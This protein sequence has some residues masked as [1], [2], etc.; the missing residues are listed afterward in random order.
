MKKPR[1]KSLSKKVLALFLSIAMVFG[2]IP[3]AVKETKAATTVSNPRI[4][5]GV[6]TW[7]CIYFGNYYQSNSST[8]EKIKWRVLS[9]EGNYAFVVA[10]QALDYK[11]YNEERTDVTWETCSLRK[12]L[13]GTFLNTAFN[14]T[15]QS[16]IKTTTVVNEDNI[17]DIPGGNNTSDK[18]FLLS[19]NEVGNQ[20]YGFNSDYDEKSETRQCKA[21]A[22]AYVAVNCFWWLRSPG[23]WSHAA[24]DVCDDGRGNRLG[25]NVVYDFGVRPALNVNLSSSSWSYGGTVSANMGKGSGSSTP[26]SAPTPTK[27]P[28]ASSDKTVGTSGSVEIGENQSGSADSSSGVSQFFPDSWTMKSTKYPLELSQTTNADGTYSIKGSIGIGR[29]D[30]LDK[31]SE[32]KKYKAACDKANKTMS[33]YDTLLAY[34]DMFGLKSSTVIHSSGWTGST[35][36]ELSIMGYIENTYDAY[37]NLIKADGRV[38][39][40]MAWKGGTTW[41][42]ATPIG[43]MYLKFEAG[44]KIN[45]SLGP[46]WDNKV[47][48]MALNGSLTITPSISLTGGYGFDGVISVS[49]KGQCSLPIDLVSRNQGTWGSKGTFKAEASVNAYAI[50]V[51]DQTWTL[52]T[53]KKTLWDTSTL[54]KSSSKGTMKNDVKTKLMSTD[55]SEE[56]TK[57][58]GKV[59]SL[60]S[61]NAKTLQGGILKSSIP[62]SA[63]IS[64]KNVLVWQDYAPERSV[65]NSSILKY[66]VEKNGVWSTPKPVYDDGFGDSFVDLKV[67]KDE[68]YIVWQKQKKKITT[69]DVDEVMGEMGASSE[70]YFAKFNKTKDTFENVKQLTNNSECDMLPKFTENTDEISITYI[71]NDRGDINQSSG[72]NTIKCMNVTEETTKDLVTTEQAIGKHMSFQ[73]DGNTEVVY[74]ATEG[75]TVSLQ[76]TYDDYDYYLDDVNYDYSEMTVGSMNYHDGIIDTIVNGILY[77]YEI[78]K[79]DFTMESAGEVTFDTN[80]TYVTNG[81]KSAYI[82]STFDEE[83]KR[84]LLKA[85]L[86]DESGHY[87]NPIE[88][89]DTEDNIVRTITP[90]LDE[91]GNWQIIANEEKSEDGIHSLVY[92]AKEE[93]TSSTLLSAD[94]NEFESDD[95]DATGIDFV[96]QN[97]GDTPIDTIKIKVKAEDGTEVSK[98]MAVRLLPGEIIAETAYIDLTNIS[99]GQNIKVSICEQNESIQSD[100]TE[101]NYLAKSNV[102]IV[103]NATE[104]DGVITVSALVENKETSSTTGEI[105]LYSDVNENTLLMQKDNIKFDADEVKQVDFSVP[106]E[107]IVYDENN[108]AYLPLTVKLDGGDYNESDNTAYVALYK[109]KS[110]NVDTTAVKTESVVVEEE[111]NETSPAP[112]GNSQTKP[113]TN[114][115]SSANN[116]T[117]TVT[118]TQNTFTTKNTKS[119]LGKVKKLKA[120]GTEKSLK[121]TWKKV[122]G[123]SGYE[124]QYSLKKNFKKPKKIT[125]KKASTK[126]KTIKGLKKKKK[127]YVRIRA[128][129]KSGKKKI[130]SKWTKISKKTK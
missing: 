67:I 109:G 65:A 2:M 25:N 82:W 21:T 100:N 29:S 96:Y 46:N 7:D 6:T 23:Y 101:T 127:Y 41:S 77:Q 4:S 83:T 102:A 73:V 22:Y 5:N 63:K 68:L 89:F 99:K 81:K 52:A 40:E 19:Q 93:D 105:S 121:L 54:S 33:E 103:A 110:A 59:R 78:E 91:D 17:Y 15:E 106:L 85:S 49:A 84:G 114:G 129:K 34:K 24:I 125:I 50:F 44:G 94:V 20:K 79:D 64:D 45:L 38:A 88:L 35:K 58:S 70:I 124:I 115:N 28:S 95:E 71:N 75:D 112:G 31:E 120:K 36:P 48:K 47:K 30:L 10:D 66:S 128:Y 87:T 117:N 12:W 26:T 80:A 74:T 18:I 98:E 55:F 116:N 51:L 113:S 27:K 130:Y 60:N 8:K 14:A 16:A 61:D 42:F 123:A 108:A 119:T 76:S 13:N 92:Y 56:T 90:S 126:S 37:G 32:W 86:Q 107:D 57:W 11:P 111:G 1:N 43:P 72:N 53:Y 62:I 3:L 104:Q 122:S 9:V 39:G 97:K 69:L 118:T